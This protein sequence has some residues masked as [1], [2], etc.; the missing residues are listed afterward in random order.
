MCIRDSIMV[1]KTFTIGALL[2]SFHFVGPGTHELILL[3]MLALLGG[4]NSIP[5]SYTHLDVYKRQVHGRVKFA[6]FDDLH[7]IPFQIGAQEIGIQVIAAR[8]Q[9]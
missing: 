5:V 4:A 7:G 8:F 3:G 6:E 2:A 1:V 9:G